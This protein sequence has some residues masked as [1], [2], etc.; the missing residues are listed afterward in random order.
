MSK[1][2][3]H[4]ATCR[5]YGGPVAAGAWRPARNGIMWKT[6]T[7]SASTVERWASTTTIRRLVLMPGRHASFFGASVAAPMLV[8]SSRPSTIP[9][10][11]TPPFL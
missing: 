9:A 8:D 4:H 5:I 1:A 10:P 6:G 2:R 11:R 7:A 3:P